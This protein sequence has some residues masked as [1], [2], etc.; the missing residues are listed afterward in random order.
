VIGFLVESI[1]DWQL[2]RFKTNNPQNAVLRD[3]LWKYSRH[4]NYLGESLVWWGLFVVIV[5][6]S[7]AWWTIISPLLL[8]LSLRYV[9]GVPM[10]ETRY[11]DN[12]EYQEYMQEVNPL[13]PFI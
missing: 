1:S 6:I 10:V 2:K 7:S 3:G 8:T 9:S 11:A 13:F 5:S 12:E 4:P